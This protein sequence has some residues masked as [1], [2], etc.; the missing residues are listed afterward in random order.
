MYRPTFSLSGWTRMPGWLMVHGGEEL[1]VRPWSNQDA[2]ACLLS[3]PLLSLLSH[4]LVYAADRKRRSRDLG[5]PTCRD[6]KELWPDAIRSLRGLPYETAPQGPSFRLPGGSLLHLLFVPLCSGEKF[7]PVLNTSNSSV[8]PAQLVSPCH[9]CCTLGKWSSS[10][11]FLP[12][13]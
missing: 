12:G 6:R 9:G 1:G 7:L 13:C 11:L 2:P 3:F 10:F 5:S 4:T 8:F